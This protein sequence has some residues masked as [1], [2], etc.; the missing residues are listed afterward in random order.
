MTPFLP[1]AKVEKRPLGGGTPT[2]MTGYGAA[3]ETSDSYP[4]DVEPIV[5]TQSINSEKVIDNGSGDTQRSLDASDFQQETSTEQT[6]TKIE[7]V[8]ATVE[9]QESIEK[10]E[11]G[12]TENLRPGKRI[13]DANQPGDAAPGNAIYD[14]NNYHQ[15]LNHPSKQK[16][17]WSTVIIIIV[18]IVVAALVAGG[19]Y[20][21]FARG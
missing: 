10:V 8:E 1:D 19:A 7:S 12:D 9:A 4:E 14:V 20:L 6:L 16:S 15:P 17:G 13:Y 2:T 11:S 3:V 18:I 21:F 5:E